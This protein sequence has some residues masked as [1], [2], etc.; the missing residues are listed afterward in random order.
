MNKFFS[1]V[2]ISALTFSGVFANMNTGIEKQGDVY[3]YTL[4]STF[5]PGLDVETEPVSCSIGITTTGEVDAQEVYL[6][7]QDKKSLTTCYN[8]VV[9]KV[10]A[11]GYVLMETDDALENLLESTI[12]VQQDLQSYIYFYP[13]SFNNDLTEN[14]KY[15]MTY[16]GGGA[17][18]SE[19]EFRGG[20]YWDTPAWVTEVDFE[21]TY[22]DIHETIQTNI[23][24][25]VVFDEVNDAIIGHENIPGFGF[26]YFLQA[27]NF[28][29]MD[30]MIKPYL[31]TFG[32]I[33][34]ESENFEDLIT[35]I[36]A[37][38][39]VEDLTYVWEF[40][41]L[42]TPD[43]SGFRLQLYKE[44]TIKGN[45]LKQNDQTDNIDSNQNEPNTNVDST[46]KPSNDAVTTNKPNVQEKGP[47]TGDITHMS[48]FMWIFAGALVSLI[49]LVKKY[50][51]AYTNKL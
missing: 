34:L 14:S 5:Y 36:R 51:N 16:T 42:E 21:N 37:Y 22:L 24:K 7:E 46:V 25:R 2:L 32:Q 4:T 6:N 12:P 13:L 10:T 50:K 15:K 29:E 28:Q 23:T 9:K 49:L 45:Q 20:V 11:K 27:N 41:P 8:A 33:S 48:G 30:A 26:E 3:T 40:A 38:N 39:V 35:K 1:S 44:Y 43:E 19:T 18:S 31:K 47:A 17:A